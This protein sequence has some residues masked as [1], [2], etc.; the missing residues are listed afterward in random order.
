MHVARV[1][2]EAD[3]VVAD[4]QVIRLAL[5]FGDGGLGCLD[6]LRRHAGILLVIGSQLRDA[7]R[8]V[9]QYRVL[10]LEVGDLDGIGYRHCHLRPGQQGIQIVRTDGLDH[11]EVIHQTVGAATDPKPH[12]RYLVTG[13]QLRL[14]MMPGEAACHVLVPVRPV[15]PRARDCFMPLPA[16]VAQHKRRPTAHFTQKRT[17]DESELINREL[18]LPPDG[19]GLWPGKPQARLR[20]E[21]VALFYADL[22]LLHRPAVGILDGEAVEDVVSVGEPGG[23]TVLGYPLVAQALLGEG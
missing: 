8:R 3:G 19:G 22:A 7:L 20:V 14:E 21:L 23:N 16:R 2:V 17:C 12:R 15:V 18:S 4:R 1:I 6:A 9:L 5:P 13:L 10:H 11:V